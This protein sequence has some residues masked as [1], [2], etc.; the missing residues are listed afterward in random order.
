MSSVDG[1][2]PEEDR[3][4]RIRHT[5]SHLLAAAVLEIRPDVQLGI[6]PPVSDGFYYDFLTETPFSLK[7]LPKIEKR[8]RKLAKQSHDMERSFLTAD[9]ARELF[10][11]DGADLKVELI[12]DLDRVRKE[13]YALDI[14]ETLLGRCCVGVAIPS[15]QMTS[16]PS[17]GVA[18]SIS[19]SEKRWEA[20]GEALITQLLRAR[21]EI[22]REWTRRLSMT[23]HHP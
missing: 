5:L 18:M 20:D 3:L 19:A 17:D 23:G 12:D 1:D 7:D 4:F 11:E 9:A 21:D 6:G 10:G 14:G 22:N 8:T 2:S 13:G 16:V 15:G